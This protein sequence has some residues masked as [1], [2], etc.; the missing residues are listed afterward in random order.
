MYL[1]LYLYCLLYFVPEILRSGT[2]RYKWGINFP[3]IRRLSHGSSFCP[4]K[5]RFVCVHEKIAAKIFTAKCHHI[6]ILTSCSVEKIISKIRFFD[7][8]QNFLILPKNWR[9]TLYFCTSNT[10][11]SIKIMCL[12][13]C[14]FKNRKNGKYMYFVLDQK[15]NIAQR[16]VFCTWN[17]ITESCTCVNNVWKSQIVF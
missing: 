9:K 11:F 7:L 5:L 1:Y 8:P 6:L 10:R 15:Q 13:F 14:A 3:K 2:R 4:S 17:Q 12:Y 16:H